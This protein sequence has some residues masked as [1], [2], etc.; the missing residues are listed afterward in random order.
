MTREQAIQIIVEAARRFAQ[1]LAD[2]P[3]KEPQDEAR[4]AE[5]WT[6]IAAIEESSLRRQW[7]KRDRG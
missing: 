3:D 6:A 1:E 2:D 4:E 5:I 7:S